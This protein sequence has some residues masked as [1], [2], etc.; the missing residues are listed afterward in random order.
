MRDSARKGGETIQNAAHSK[1]IWL[2]DLHIGAAWPGTDLDPPAQ[3]TRAVDMIRDHHADALAC[4]VSGDMAENGTEAEYRTL[5]DLLGDLPMPVLPM[6]GNHDRREPLMAAFPPP[7]RALDGFQQYR[8]DF[9][10]LSLIALD[11]LVPGEA[12]GTLCPARIAWLTEELARTPDTPALVFM[13]HPPMELGMPMLD[14]MRCADGEAILDLL[15]GAGNVAHLF[16]GHVHRPASGVARGVP[17]ATLRSVAM[18]APPPW[19]AWDWQRFAPVNE[20][21]ALG[22]VLVRGADV[23]IQPLDLV[24]GSGATRSC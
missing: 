8:V 9:D 6:A 4:V 7:G 21:P 17:F 22:V 23:T 5:A 24:A 13:H 11:T 19:P 3:L 12:G 2:T 14:A 1:I 18:Q 16:C 10:G 20:N 15:A